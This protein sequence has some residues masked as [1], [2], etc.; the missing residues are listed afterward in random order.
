MQHIQTYESP[1]GELTFVSDGIALLG[2]WYEKQEPLEQLL[3]SPY[4]MC[5]L[6]VF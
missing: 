4:E 2:V 3:Q 1:L 5:N 6:P